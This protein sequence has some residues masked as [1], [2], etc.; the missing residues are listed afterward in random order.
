MNTQLKYMP[1]LRVRQEEVKVLNTFNFGERIY[2]CI[3]IIKELDRAPSP[4][5]PNA[6][7][8]AKPKAPKTFESV[9]LPLIKN[10]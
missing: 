10:I 7:K 5:K 1:I 8:P 2:P 6:K 9:Y 4:P 3:E